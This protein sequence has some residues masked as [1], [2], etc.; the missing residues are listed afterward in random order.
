MIGRTLSHYKIVEELSR[1][2]MGIVYRAVDVKLNRDVA[3]KVLP[4]E[5]VADPER[6]RRFVQEAQ[7]AAAL[8]HPHIAVIY[9]IDEVDGVTFIAMELI[10]GEKLRDLL[11]RG[12]PALSRSLELGT[13]VA[14]GLARAHDKGIVHRDLKPA[15]VMVTE[16]GHAKIIDFGLAKL[17]EPLEQRSGQASEIETLLQ[18]ETD[19]GII[20]GTVSYMSP[21]QAR[22][23]RV[24]HRSDIFSFGVLLYEM[25][26]GRPPFQGASGI[27]TLNAIL[28]E[29]APHLPAL[30]PNTS[31]E[32]AFDIQR[33]VEKCL[34]KEP[35]ERYQ[36]IKDLV[37]DLR[38]ARRRLDSGSLAPVRVSRRLRVRLLLGA[39]AAA[40]LLLGALA[41]F[42]RPRPRSDATGPRAKPSVAILY[43][44]NNTGD[45]SLDWLRTALT[46]MLVTDLSQSPQ[47]EVLGTDRLY[48]ILKEMNR[49]DERVTSFDVVQ[50]VAQR[51]NV[52][53]VLLGNFVKAG[54]S[55]RI[56]VRLQE[57]KSG[58]IVTSEKVEGSASPV[59][60][61]WWTTSR[62]ASR[63]GSTSRAN[64]R[65]SWTET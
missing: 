21:E 26:A 48:Q 32:A 16:D 20:L 23:G 7:A 6:R 54:E 11:T 24:D 65:P 14:E 3:L 25:L 37:L 5:L 34:A 62:G 47:M 29:P 18:K 27:E 4:P 33:V 8:D 10:R 39:I 51:A 1:G 52:T 31:A 17:V 63:P 44:E 22:G 43:F 50:E 58:K 59:S 46:N 13:E 42:L 15:N 55:I 12:T 56:S 19:P 35:N 49:L 41:L 60:F 38:S 45:P 28:K 57:A 30:G 36:T 61:R 64:R 40:V 9:E 2:G 53:T